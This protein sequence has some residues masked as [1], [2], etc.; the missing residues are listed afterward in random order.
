MGYTPTFD[1]FALLG[2]CGAFIT[3]VLISLLPLPGAVRKVLIATGLLSAIVGLVIGN[4]EGLDG[5]GWAIIAG[6]SVLAWFAGLALGY[7]IHRIFQPIGGDSLWSGFVR[8]VSL[9]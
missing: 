1:M 7:F 5:I 9:R 3:G 2:T 6:Y 8:L 4:P